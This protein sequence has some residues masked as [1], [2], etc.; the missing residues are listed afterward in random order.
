V[1]ALLLDHCLLIL[2]LIDYAYVIFD[3]LKRHHA[4]IVL[5]FDEE[6][7]SLWAFSRSTLVHWIKISFF[8]S[9]DYVVLQLKCFVGWKIIGGQ[10]IIDHQL[11][12]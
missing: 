7:K 5:T 1:F 9:Q 3:I 12:R 11:T 6:F 4:I 8:A 2:D 10:D